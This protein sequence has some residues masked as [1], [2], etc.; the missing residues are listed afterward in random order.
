MSSSSSATASSL[1]AGF[2]QKKAASEQAKAADQA[3]AADHAGPSLLDT[4]HKHGLVKLPA[5]A[6]WHD[7]TGRFWSQLYNKTLSRGNIYV[8]L[9]DVVQPDAAEPVEAQ[10]QYKGLYRFNAVERLPITMHDANEAKTPE[11]VTPPTQ[12]KGHAAPHGKGTL[13]FKIS[14][15]VGTKIHGT[16][17]LTHPKDHGRFELEQGM[18]HG[19]QCAVM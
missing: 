18:E 7:Y 19:E 17:E 13:I 6:G 1:F 12:V 16:Y 9:P 11:F 15:R 2:Q 8:Q 10:I 14:Q 4:L 3:A 5:R